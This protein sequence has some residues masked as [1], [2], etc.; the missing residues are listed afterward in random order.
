MKENLEE[1]RLI[2]GEQLRVF[3]ANALSPAKQE[4]EQEEEG[5]RAHYCFSTF[6]KLGFW[7]S[8]VA[9]FETESDAVE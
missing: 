8:G 7:K 9:P 2:L 3:V 5:G 1:V 6:T 4:K